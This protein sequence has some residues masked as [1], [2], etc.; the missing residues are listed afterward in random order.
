MEIKPAI[1]YFLGANSSQGFYSLYKDFVHPEDGDFLWVI[2]GGPGC[3]KSTFMKKIGK[4]AENAGLTV[5][6]ILCSGDPESLDGV[7]IKEKRMAYVDGTAPHIMDCDLPGG[8]GL[9]LDLGAFYHPDPLVKKRQ[10][11]LRLFAAYK[12]QYA[13]AYALLRSAEAVAPECVPGLVTEDVLQQV[14]KRAESLGM[15]YIPTGAGHSVKTRFLSGI[16]GNGICRLWESVTKQCPRVVTLDDDL[17]LADVFLQTIRIVAIRKEQPVILCPTPLNPRRLEAVLLPE[18]GLAFVSVY[19]RDPWP[20]DIWR[21][22]RLDAMI[23]EDVVRACREEYRSARRLQGE[24]L[25]S[26][27]RSLKEARRL[28]DELEGVYNPHVDFAGL[29][30]LCLLHVDYLLGQME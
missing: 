15:R 13:R 11:L 23:R 27:C 8:G 19:R 17:G 22:L 6:Y 9:Y 5:E 29:N 14:D 10:E 21:H 26:A 24:L 20:G 3:G 16:S 4:A 28:H 12:A 7:Y 25:E 18:A 2:K 1:A 30:E